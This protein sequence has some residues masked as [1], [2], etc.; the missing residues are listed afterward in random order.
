MTI[1]HAIKELALKAGI[2]LNRHNPAQSQHARMLRL[3]A[4]HGID[5]VLDVGAND[6]GYGRFLRKSG[7]RCNILSFEPLAGVH[8]ALTA[9]A[10]SDPRWH[11]ASRMALG[12]E[13]GEIE[14]NV[15][16]NS[17][18]SSVLPMLKSHVEAAPGSDY[19]G[20]ENVRLAR[21]DSLDHP[22]IAEAEYIY[23]KIDTQGYEKPV[24]DGAERLLHKIVG[25]QLEMSLTPLYEGQLLFRKMLDE[26]DRLGYEPWGLL[27]GF[28]DQRSGRLM[29]IDGIFFRKG[30]PLTKHDTSDLL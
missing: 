12:A 29:Q 4:H 3:L 20:K 5:T 9:A 25:I 18:S 30:D 21:L 23:L 26:L 8:R 11:V 14:I 22:W 1:K 13:D 19:V 2:E 10:A 16:G 7:Y 6:G 24:L 28:L 17:T 27:P 15:A